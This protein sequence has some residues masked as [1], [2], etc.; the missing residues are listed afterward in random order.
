MGLPVLAR[1]P[2]RKTADGL[3]IRVRVTP[4]AIVDQVAGWETGAD[5]RPYLKVRI[6]AVAERGKA[7]QAL[8]RL[9][10]KLLNEPAAGFEIVTGGGA[11]LKQVLVKGDPAHLVDRLQATLDH[12]G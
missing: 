10:S 1:L 2:V 3:V 5:K 8:I 11:R 7:N 9:L 6:R 12:G 4:G